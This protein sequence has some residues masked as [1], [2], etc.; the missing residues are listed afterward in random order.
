[1]HQSTV[2]YYRCVLM[3]WEGARYQSPANW[4]LIVR[5]PS[6]WQQYHPTCCLCQG[7]AFLALS[8]LQDTI[9]REA[10][11]AAL[12]S[13]LSI[14]K[15]WRVDTGAQ[16]PPAHC[17]SQMYTD[18][19]MKLSQNTDVWLCCHCLTLALY[20][21]YHV[22]WIESFFLGPDLGSSCYCISS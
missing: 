16:S 19:N 7:S 1:M 11:P 13:L 3:L 21:L 5:I 6:N 12:V 22:C 9:C 10:A 4:Q 2:K 17:L 8:P 18:R 20:F 14:C 15:G